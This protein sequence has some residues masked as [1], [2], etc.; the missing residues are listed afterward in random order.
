MERE[1][2]VKSNQL[3]EASYHLGLVEQRIMVMSIVKARET[4]QGVTPETLLHV[5]ADEYAKLFDV[6]P[7]TAYEA[8]T[9]AV[10]TLF[11]RRLTIQTYDEKL[12]KEV[13]LTIRWLTGMNYLKDEGMVSLRFTSEI[14]PHITRLESNFTSYPLGEV[15]GL[16]SGYAVRLYEL[17]TKWRKIGKT[18]LIE[19]DLFRAQLGIAEG[20]Y[21]RV[22]NLK[23]RVLDI[24]L[25]QINA[26]TDLVASYEQQK[27]G[28]IITGFTFDIKQKKT[29]TAAKIEDKAPKNPKKETQT[30]WV[31]SSKPVFSAESVK[32]SAD[33]DSLADD[34]KTLVLKNIE[35]E[36]SGLRRSQFAIELS[37]YNAKKSP[38][39]FEQYKDY[40]S[41]GLALQGYY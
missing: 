8:L 38:A 27:A 13:P 32:M 30:D 2:V 7:H 26:N 25:E 29:K 18:P 35:K 34:D 31:D 12:K 33:F 24:A 14:L 41:R 22:Q 3:I 19:L 40:F 28:R 23:L 21:N 4:G 9:D 15:S 16:Q 36:L 20:E 5:R 6:E 39:I 37:A 10:S 17:L 11:N 1:L